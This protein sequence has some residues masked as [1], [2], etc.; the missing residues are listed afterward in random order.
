MGGCFP[1]PRPPPTPAKAVD[2][3]LWLTLH[4]L[5][6]NVDGLLLGADTNETHDVGV[7]VLLQNPGGQ[8]H[9]APWLWEPQE[10]Q[11]DQ[12]KTGEGSR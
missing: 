4:K 10:P 11:G 9:L 3:L 5:H 12:G 6:D 8:H 1:T 2:Q 7:V